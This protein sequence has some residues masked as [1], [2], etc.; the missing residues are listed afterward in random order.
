M[1]K[2]NTLKKVVVTVV[3]I[4]TAIHVVNRYITKKADEKDLLKNTSGKYYHW[5]YGN[6]F[7]KE[8]GEGSPILLVH[9]VNECS[10][11]EEWSNLEKELSKTNKVYTIDLLGCGRSDRP[12]FMYNNYL[13]V[14]LLTDFIKDVIK[15]KA[16][17]AATGMAAA[18]AV[19]AAK[20]SPDHIDKLTLINP[21]DLYELSNVPTTH[22]KIKKTLICCPIFGTFFYHMTHKKDDIFYLFANQYYA[23]YMA[24]FEDL[25]DRYYESAHKLESG[26][27]YLYASIKGNY[28]NLNINHALKTL[29]HD[30]TILCGEYCA[31]A[32]LI[33]KD[34]VEL[35]PQ[36]HVQT[37]SD[38]AY[39]PQ[40][41]FPEAVLSVL[42]EEKD[43]E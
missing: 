16:S 7:Y 34:Y 14:Q 4:G 24:D 28:L 42:A 8:S 41:E 32:K 9:D 29:T 3:M 20:I 10:S 31:D 5:K 43:A 25:C 33:A 18:S 40:L 37:I 36:I 15:E 12:N 38:T 39:L 30:T 21:A 11:G 6:I 1:G 22:S 23:D 13:Y 2:N 17:I 35:N 19:M 27:K 26:S